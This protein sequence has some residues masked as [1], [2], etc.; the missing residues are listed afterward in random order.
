MTWKILTALNTMPKLYS[1]W[2]CFYILILM[3]DKNTTSCG[4]T[5]L[6]F[7]LRNRFWAAKILKKRHFY[8]KT[9][10]I[11]SIFRLFLLIFY[12]SST[13]FYIFQQVLCQKLCQNYAV[14]K[15][16]GG[17]IHPIFCHSFCAYLYYNITCF[18]KKTH[19][20]VHRF[21]IFLNTNTYCYYRSISRRYN[22]I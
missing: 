18:I 1:K 5:R 15:L 2:F 12:A 8:C 4:F 6:K 10:D 19:F 11:L 7:T 3:S 16:R 9:C 13:I 14:W 20:I 21:D 17:V 22:C